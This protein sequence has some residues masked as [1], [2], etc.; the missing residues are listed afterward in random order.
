MEISK[1]TGTMGLHYYVCLLKILLKS[2]PL[3]CKKVG[4]VSLRLVSL[5]LDAS[6]LDNL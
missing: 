4:S 5:N 6:H 3:I 1:I 2:M